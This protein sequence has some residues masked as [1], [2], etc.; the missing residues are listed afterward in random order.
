MLGWFQALMPK[1]EKFFDYFE[2]H[3][4]I[5]NDAA[6]A[7]QALLRG[8]DSIAINGERVRTLEDQADAVI[9][10]VLLAVRRSF[11]TPFDRS[12]IQSLISSMDDAID[13]MRSTVKAIDL[14]EVTQFEPGMQ[15]MGDIIV[16]AAKLTVEAV[17]SLRRMNQ[18]AAKLHGIAGRL[19]R[20]EQESDDLHDLG[21]KGLF[22][23]SAGGDVMS[24]IIGSEIYAHLE[25][26][27]DRFE[28]VADRVNAIVI[29]HV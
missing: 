28:D 17:T 29:E 27:V 21:L 23:A 22:K 2:K 19:T 9:R 18:N 5:L 16:D 15:K 25:K 4:A 20:L 1:E 11:I 26:V 7:L 8:G 12:D 3:A 10:D 24:Y 13:Q 6:M 14:Y